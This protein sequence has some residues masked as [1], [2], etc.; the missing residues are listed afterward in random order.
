MPKRHILVAAT[1]VRLLQ[2]LRVRLQSEGYT[3]A[4]AQRAEQMTE[5]A[6]T[7]RPDVLLVNDLDVPAGLA[8][9]PCVS[10]IGMT[11]PNRLIAEI[12]EAAGDAVRAPEAL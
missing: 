12:R 9:I 10:L 7:D 8:S 2:A 1:D 5:R 3:V 4:L 11:D 6:A